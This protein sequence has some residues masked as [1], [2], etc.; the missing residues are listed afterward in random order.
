MLMPRCYCFPSTSRGPKA[1]ITAH[2]QRVWIGRLS[3]LEMVPQQGD[4]RIAWSESG[5]MLRTQSAELELGETRSRGALA[6]RTLRLTTLESYA[7]T[8]AEWSFGGI[9]SWDS[10]QRSHSTDSGNKKRRAASF[11]R[12]ALPWNQKYCH[13]F[14]VSF[15]LKTKF[16]N[17]HRVTLYVLYRNVNLKCIYQS[18]S[19]SMH[20]KVPPSAPN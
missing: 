7:A 5:L 15:V 3:R 2:N 20:H 16:S 12:K 13:A 8:T 19:P 4:L 1:A 17:C 14:I 9:F 18:S 6:A 11:I 10:S